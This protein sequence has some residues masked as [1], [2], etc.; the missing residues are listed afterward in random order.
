M[1]LPCQNDATLDN[2]ERP[3]SCL[4]ISGGEHST[5]DIPIR[6]IPLAWTHSLSGT[7]HVLSPDGWMQILP[8]YWRRRRPRNQL[9]IL[10]QNS[11]GRKA[12]VL[13]ALPWTDK[14]NWN[15]KRSLSK[16]SYLRCLALI[17][18]LYYSHT[19]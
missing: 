18:V 15:I 4:V 6:S 12:A 5:F 14:H 2:R 1:L 3:G 7:V 11:Q 19:L 8:K 13:L 16:K 10:C 17:T 9:Q